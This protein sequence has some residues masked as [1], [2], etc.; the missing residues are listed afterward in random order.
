VGRDAQAVALFVERYAGE[1]APASTGVKAPSP[2]G[3]SG[4][5]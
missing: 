4:T 1:K 5:K 3:S 2:T